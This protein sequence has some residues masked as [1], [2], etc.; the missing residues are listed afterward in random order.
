MHRLLVL[1]PPPTDPAAFREYYEGNH[2]PLAAR[3][4]GLR[5]LRWGF[6]V[7]APGGDSPYFCVFEADFDDAGALDA[8]LASPEGEATAADVPEE[9]PL[10]VPRRALGVGRGREARSVAEQS[11]PRRRHSPLPARG[12]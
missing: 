10:G 6:D 12:L 3:M 9:R 1:Y 5:G 7:A 8:A 11:C 4:P 2:L